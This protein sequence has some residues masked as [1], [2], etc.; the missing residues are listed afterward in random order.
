MT[1]KLLDISGIGAERLHIEWVSSAEAQ[2]FVDTAHRVTDCV[3]KC[4][5]FKPEDFE[6]ELE[7]VEMTLENQSIRWLVGKESAI[8]AKGDVYGRP[9]DKERYED[10]IDNELEREYQKNLIFLS[11]K[12]GD[13][14]VRDVAKSAGIELLR[15]SY[16]LADL[17]RSNR[18]EFSGM[19]DRKP[20]F[21]AI[22]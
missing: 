15:V 16:L 6:M 17:E 7:A 8:T 13:R 1:K 12:N 3:Q 4:G 2:R 9:W 22:G 19:E 10:V 14:S 5:K 20:A 11:I 18:V 21:T